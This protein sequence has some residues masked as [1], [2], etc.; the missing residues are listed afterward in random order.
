[1]FLNL[2]ESLSDQEGKQRQVRNAN[3]LQGAENKSSAVCLEATMYPV[4]VKAGRVVDFWVRL[5]WLVSASVSVPFESL[6]GGRKSGCAR[7]LPN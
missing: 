7:Q 5:S 3:I 6:D 4:G 2:S 1:M